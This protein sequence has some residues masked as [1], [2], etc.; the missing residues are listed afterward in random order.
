MKPNI[1]LSNR[2]ELDRSCRRAPRAGLRAF[3]L[4]ELAVAMGLLGFMVV[5]LYAGLTS[6]FA[7]LRVA[8][9]NLRA[10]QILEEHMEL[11]R[12]INW[13]D[14]TTPGFIPA[15]FNASFD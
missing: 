3:T 1:K 15:T 10:T 14:V 9:E 13:H 12:L 2:F 6:G 7:V 5:S 11:I 4:M 8:R